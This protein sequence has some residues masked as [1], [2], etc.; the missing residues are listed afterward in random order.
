METRGDKS[1]IMVTAD[2]NNK[3]YKMHD[4]TDGTFTV[5]YGRVGVTETTMNYP[6]KKWDSIYRDKTGKGYR[7][8][9]ELRAEKTV[10]NSNGNTPSFADIKIAQIKSLVATLQSYAKK[11]V[12]ENYTVT[13]EAVTQAQVDE[14]QS[15][16][17]R[18]TTLKVTDT[19]ILNDTLLELYKVIPRR[20]ANVKHHLFGLEE[21]LDSKPDIFKR[22]IETEQA[23]LDVMRGQVSTN[24]KTKDVSNKANQTLLEAMGLEIVPIEDSDRQIIL[25][26]LGPNSRQF[27]SAFKVINVKTQG[28]FD[29]KLVEVTNKSTNLFWHGS[30]NE[31]WWSILDSG[32]MIRPSNAIYTGSMF[33]DGIYFADK[34]QK[35]IGYTSL[36]GS[37]W[38]GGGSNKAYLAVFNVHT[39][40][41]LKAQRHESWMY[42]LTEKKLKARGAYDSF[43]AL[44]G[45]DLRNNEYIVYNKAQ[46]TVQYLVEIGD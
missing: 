5:K 38:A 30:R 41:W 43:F 22:T 37:Y 23:T 15:V 36:R 18:I 40:N 44:D 32:L 34:A 14:A 6:I 46:C 12:T 11:S 17:D 1:L 39:G 19:K 24:T 42:E 21:G 28:L 25:K 13:S 9:T 2:N 31:N 26:L 8:V 20:M 33:G 29:K 45:A 7:D 35:S 10:N 4:N 16:L 3:F 27:R